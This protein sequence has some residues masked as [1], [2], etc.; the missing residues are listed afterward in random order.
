MTPNDK[1]PEEIREKINTASQEYE[2][3]TQHEGLGPAIFKAGVDYAL[4]YA[5]VMADNDLQAQAQAMADALEELNKAI[6]KTW[7]ECNTKSIPDKY[8]KE[9]SAAQALS[10]N[11][12]QQFKDGK[13]VGND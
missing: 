7:N 11:V 5:K 2:S 12:L 4:E 10:C 9:I 6:D 13:E 8:K 1:L 3:A